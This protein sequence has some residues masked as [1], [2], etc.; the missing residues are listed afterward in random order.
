MSSSWTRHCQDNALAS[1]SRLSGGRQKKAGAALGHP[2]ADVSPSQLAAIILKLCHINHDTVLRMR[3]L[4]EGVRTLTEN[5]PLTVPDAAKVCEFQR[6]CSVGKPFEAITTVRPDARPVRAAV[7]A[8]AS[9]DCALLQGSTFPAMTPVGD[10]TL[11][12][13]AHAR[14]AG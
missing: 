12:E 2:I 5:N 9:T 14:R 3:R 13:V 10:A 11:S 7:V 1:P 8:N 6:V 4:C